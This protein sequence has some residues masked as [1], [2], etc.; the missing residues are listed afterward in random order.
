M[1]C[2]IKQAIKNEKGSAT[3]EFLGMLP[4]VAIVMVLVW[5]MVVSV[6][7]V[8]IAQSA[9]N[10]AAKVYSITENG[11]EAAN[12]AQKIV[13]AGGTYLT[14]EGTTGLNERNFTA[15]V[16]VRIA[17]VFL[18]K[19]WFADHRTPSLSFSSAASGKVIKN[20]F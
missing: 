5:Q 6:H 9:A 1:V 3:I 4:F 13:S 14:Y 15:K 11:T 12:A 20:G 17:L 19:K 2:N 18:P 16:N 10:E 7:S 8:I